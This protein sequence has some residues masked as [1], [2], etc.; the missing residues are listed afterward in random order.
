MRLKLRV[1]PKS[2][3]DELLGVTP[4]GVVRVRV[5]AAPQD[6]EANQA[7]LRLL[8]RALGVPRSA[9]RIKAGAGARDKW[10]EVEGLEAAEAMRLLTRDRT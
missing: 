5:T 9:V 4:D 10:V 6:G 8:S 3:S 2:R 7:V 1:T